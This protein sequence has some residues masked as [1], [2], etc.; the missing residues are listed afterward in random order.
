MHCICLTDAGCLIEVAPTC[1][2]ADWGTHLCRGKTLGVVGFGDIGKAAA[3][4]ARAFGMRIVALRRR[5]KLSAQEQEDGL[6]V[7][8]LACWYLSPWCVAKWM[9]CMQKSCAAALECTRHHMTA[10]NVSLTMACMLLVSWSLKGRQ[11]L[12]RHLSRNRFAA[13]H[14]AC[15]Q[16]SV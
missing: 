15:C 4:I 11:P 7:T 14:D 3:R 2:L 1:L 9:S 5:A 13:N 10:H 8:A 6:Q 12:S 16:H